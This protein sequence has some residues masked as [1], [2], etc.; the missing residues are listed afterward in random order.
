MQDRSREFVLFNFRTGTSVG[1]VGIERLHMEVVKS[2]SLKVFKK[3]IDVVLRN[4][5]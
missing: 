2:S 1:R 4:I 5:A 3:H